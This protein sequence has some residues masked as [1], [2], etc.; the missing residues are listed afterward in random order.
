MK[1][2]IFSHL[3]IGGSLFAI[4]I[5]KGELLRATVEEGSTI[6]A[7]QSVASSESRQLREQ[8]KNARRFSKVALERLKSNCVQTVDAQTKKDGYYIEGAMVLDSQIQR[9]LRPGIFIC[10]SLGET[11]VIA[12]DGSISSVARIALNERS[13]YDKLFNQIKGASNNGSRRKNNK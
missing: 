12:E 8:A 1:V 10:N 11:A 4:F 6:S 9:P 3:I 13:E 5:S 2:K 7:N